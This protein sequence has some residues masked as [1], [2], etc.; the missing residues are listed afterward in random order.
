MQ[1]EVIEENETS[2]E[3]TTEN[4]TGDVSSNENSSESSVVEV[5]PQQEY[6]E[7]FEFIEHQLTGCICFMGVMLGAYLC[8]ALFERFKT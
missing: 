6:I 4:N 8:K 5:E 7:H 2:E 3:N 1:D